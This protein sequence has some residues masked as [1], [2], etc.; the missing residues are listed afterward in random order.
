MKGNRKDWRVLSLPQLTQTLF[1]SF[2]W[3]LVFCWDGDR[4]T[5]PL[6]FDPHHSF[7]HSH[8]YKLG[9]EFWGK[10]MW[11]CVFFSHPSWQIGLSGNKAEFKLLLGGSCNP[12]VYVPLLRAKHQTKQSSFLKRFVEPDV[13]HSVGSWVCQLLTTLAFGWIWECCFFHMRAVIIY[14][15]DRWCC[16]RGS[17]KDT[18][19]S[20]EM[21]YL[22]GLVFTAGSRSLDHVLVDTAFNILK[23]EVLF[24]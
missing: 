21:I 2:S 12:L 17:L 4:T 22:E 24:Y 23:D 18:S 7:V 15:N 3:R 5:D 20:V 13:W 11:P 6:V 8:Y 16:Q 10:K 9:Y 1:H 14:I 19:P